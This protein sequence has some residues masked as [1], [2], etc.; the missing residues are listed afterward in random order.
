MSSADAAAEHS[1]EQLVTA[2]RTY[3]ELN[4]SGDMALLDL[5]HDDIEIYFPSF[6]VRRG[7]AAFVDLAK[8]AG[9]KVSSMQHHM[10][11]LVYNVTGRTVI[12]E[13]TT[14]G[15]MKNGQKWDGGKTSGGRFC[16]VFEFTDGL[17]SRMYVYL[18]PDFGGDRD[19]GFDWPSDPSRRW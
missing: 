19:L 6:G 8:G 3:F 17:I 15:E 18:D 5:F 13:G 11:Q 16:N 4:D 12:V 10:D 2:T 9:T 7:K 1:T 14:V